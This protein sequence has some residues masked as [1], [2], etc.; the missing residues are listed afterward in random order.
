MEEA[1]GE[2]MLQREVSCGKALGTS[3]HMMGAE[4]PYL[5]CGVRRRG[6]QKTHA[7]LAA[8][9]HSSLLDGRYKA[10]STV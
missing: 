4:R 3:T 9:K 6:I 2:T 7:S 10:R 8:T 1:E 5:V